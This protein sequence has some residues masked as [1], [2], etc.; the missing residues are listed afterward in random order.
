M[1]EEFKK[2]LRQIRTRKGIKKREL[3]RKAGITEMYMYVI[4]SPDRNQ[5]PSDSIIR[6]IAHA[7]A[8]N[9]AEE[10]QIL[11][12]LLTAK[13]LSKI[14]E[15]ARD[16]IEKEKIERTIPSESMPIEFVEKL[17]KD[18]ENKNLDE[19]S[20]KSG[21]NKEIIDSIL[22]YKRTIPR[23]DVIAL[24][25]ALN[26]SVYDY[27]LAASYI[28]DNVKNLLKHDKISSLLR[29][30]EDLSDEDINCLVDGIISIIEAYKRKTHDRTRHKS[31]GKRI[32]EKE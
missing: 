18:L 13:A 20:K 5:L 29:S 31:P 32:P 24:A 17:K 28:P 10:V 11:K 21:I 9:E 30:L 22:Q 27:L 25:M 19:I 6:R 7:L 14:P 26:Q 2:L 12:Q 1:Y 4:E 23:K 15:E 8:D 3:A 16:S